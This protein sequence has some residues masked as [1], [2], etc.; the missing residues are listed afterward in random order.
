LNTVLVL[1][2][3]FYIKPRDLYRKFRKKGFKRF[4]CEDFLQSNDPPLKKALSIALGVFIG[5]SPLW[6]F[7]TILVLSLAVLL[8]L[9]K[10]I[11]F[12]FSNLSIPPLIPFVIYLSLQTG[13]LVMG[14]EFDFS[15]NEIGKDFGSFKQLQTYII[16]SFL[17]ALFSAI[18]FGLI[19]Y[20]ILLFFNRR[21]I[22]I[23]NG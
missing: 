1:V 22:R 12:A 5:L 6:G 19:G 10:V 3:L 18:L 9:N 14:S 4:F 11:A 7:H 17:L 20:F 21:K 15:L 8:K 13:A 2:A 16:G 23:S